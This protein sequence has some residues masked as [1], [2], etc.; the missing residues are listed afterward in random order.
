MTRSGMK[1][2]E[3]EKAMEQAKEMLDKGCGMAEIVSQT[4]LSEDDVTK[5][6]NKWVDRS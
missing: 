4:H 2:G 3:H 5:A 6:K 1:K